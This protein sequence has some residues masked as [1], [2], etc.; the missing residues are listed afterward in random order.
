[1]LL[2]SLTLTLHSREG[3]SDASIE[4]DL[5]PPELVS[6]SLT[7]SSSPRRHIP[8]TLAPSPLP[9]SSSLTLSWLIPHLADRAATPYHA[10]IFLA[11]SQGF[12]AQEGIEVAILEPND[13]SDVTELIGSGKAQLGAKAMIH[14]LAAGA[15]GWGVTSIATLC[16]EPVTGVVYLRGGLLGN[17]EGAVNEEFKSLRGKRIGYVGHL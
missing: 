10:P 12:F 5:V 3:T 14:S 2:H 16:D 1:M 11:Q 13:P 9:R 15:M 6:F 8:R 7:L 17:E 4:Q